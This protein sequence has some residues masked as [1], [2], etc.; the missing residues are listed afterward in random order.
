MN[1]HSRMLVVL[2]AV[3]AVK[4]VD[5]GLHIAINEVETLRVMSNVVLV[6]GGCLGVFL[7]R[8][9][10][11]AIWGGAIGYLVLNL[12]F[13]A[14]FGLENPVTGVNRTPLFAFMALSLWL[15]YRLGRLR[16]KAGSTSPI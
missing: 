8:S 7:T 2:G 1:L 3:I 14:L 12:L 15:I 9:R 11:T 10:R 4:V 6:I 5:A 16:E 13:V